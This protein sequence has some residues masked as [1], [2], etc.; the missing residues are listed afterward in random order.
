MERS[1][2]ISGFVEK[3]NKYLVVYDPK[4]K[5]WRVPGGR[6][7]PGEKEEETVKREL[8]EEL[9]INVKVEYYLGEGIDDVPIYGHPKKNISHRKVKYYQCKYVS[10]ELKIK[11]PNE[12]SEIKWIRLGEISKIEN[13]EPAMRYFFLGPSSRDKEIRI[14]EGYT[15]DW[16]DVVVEFLKQKKLEKV[17]VHCFC[18]GPDD[19]CLKTI[20]INDLKKELNK[21]SDEDSSFGNWRIELPECEINYRFNLIIT[22]KPKYDK[23]MKLFKDLKKKTSTL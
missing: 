13:L 8:F 16:I 21:F 1:L 11:E 7:E 9:D 15:K 20:D 2:V 17:K 6:L 23:E 18:P 14:E 22:Y 10:G 5:F 4:F 12:A 19:Y 3:D